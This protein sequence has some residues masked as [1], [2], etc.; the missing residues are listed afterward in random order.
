MRRGTIRTV[1]ERGQRFDGVWPRHV[2]SKG[3]LDDQTAAG[4]EVGLAR[5]TVRVRTSR[6]ETASRQSEGDGGHDSR[7]GDEPSQCVRRPDQPE[8]SPFAE[9]QRTHG[10]KGS[11]ALGGGGERPGRSGA[12][13]SRDCWVE[14]SSRGHAQRADMDHEAAGHHYEQ[15]PGPRD[16]E[17]NERRPTQKRSSRP[18]RHAGVRKA[19]PRV[20]SS[21]VH[22]SARLASHRGSLN[23]SSPPRT[24][25]SSVVTACR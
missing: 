15:R 7:E 21:E 20:R 3:L 11:P 2:A 9:A 23:R 13:K 6:D 17:K 4:P 12:G 8:R 10:R 22:P 1:A 18:D 25:R 19:T 16:H 14:R 5:V 24:G